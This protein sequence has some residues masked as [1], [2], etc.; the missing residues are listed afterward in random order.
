MS[1]TRSRRQRRCLANESHKAH[2]PARRSAAVGGGLPLAEHLQPL[3]WPP[4][5]AGGIAALNAGADGAWQRRT[6]SCALLVMHL[7]GQ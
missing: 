7:E 2:R 4:I 1:P 5:A 6:V 3:G